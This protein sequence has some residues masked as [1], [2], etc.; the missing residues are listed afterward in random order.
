MTNLTIQIENQSVLA[1][2]ERLQRVAVNMQPA[3]NSI[4]QE[5]KGFI[6]QGFRDL[7]SPEGVNWAVLS[8]VTIA[9]RT[10]NSSEPLNDTGVLKNSFSAQGNEFSV[11]NVTN[12]SVEVGTN[13]V[14]ATM[15]N[16][17]GTKAQF[18]HLWGNIP[19]RP[20]MPTSQ[21]PNLWETA[22]IAAIQTHFEV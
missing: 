20:F 3:F 1:E 12:N 15:M 22:T 10:N 18:P 5:I 21:I 17:G 6:E 14:Q 8:P 16:F 4:G 13:R 2:L 7:R 19:A 9:K 11:F